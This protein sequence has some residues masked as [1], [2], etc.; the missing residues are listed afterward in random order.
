MMASGLNGTL[1]IGVTTN[2]Q[3]RVWQHK[4]NVIDG[5]TQKY[6][7]HFLVYYEL[8]QTMED[9]ILREKQ[10]KKWKR[11]W[12]KKLIAK[13]NPDWLDLFETL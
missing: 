2:L 5:F 3:K 13:M 4:N 11:D 10:L 12:K 1:Y 7:V 8:H 9:A 6:N